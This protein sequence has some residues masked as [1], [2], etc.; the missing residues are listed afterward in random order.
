VEDALAQV[1]VWRSILHLSYV[2]GDLQPF[3]QVV[4][5]VEGST[6]SR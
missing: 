4:D 5:I 6:Q 1:E 2:Q 3:L